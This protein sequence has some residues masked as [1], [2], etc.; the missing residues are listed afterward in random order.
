MQTQV[1]T[2]A[3]KTFIGKRVNMSFANN[4]TYQLWN[5]FMPRRSEIKNQVGSELYSAEIYPPGFFKAF[6][7]TAQFEKWAAV[8]VSATYLI[9]DGMEALHSPE[10]L[11][12]V[13]LF[14]GTTADA[15]AFYNKI[16]S[17]W[18]PANGF[19]VDDRP[20]FA[21]LGANYKH[22]DPESEEEICIPVKAIS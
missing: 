12:A 20:H 5:V 21:V 22:N 3:S 7:P 19:T 8:E 2:I 6:D 17:E 18:L 9:P 10:G 4:F 15:P 11:Y 13:F 16:F 14:K 1:K